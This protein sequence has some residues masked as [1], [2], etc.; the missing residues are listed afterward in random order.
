MIFAV[1]HGDGAIG[2]RE[3]ENAE[4]TGRAL[5]VGV[6]RDRGVLGDD[7]PGIPDGWAPEFADDG[8]LGRPRRAGVLTQALDLVERLRV[9]HA[10]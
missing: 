10:R 9:R 2:E 1:V 5:E 6:V 8:L 3:I 7:V 4:Q